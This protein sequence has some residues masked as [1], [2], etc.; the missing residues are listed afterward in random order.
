MDLKALDPC[1]IGNW[2]KPFAWQ[3]LS[4]NELIIRHCSLR[5]HIT[6]M[7]T[8]KTYTYVT[9][10]IIIIFN[11]LLQ[12]CDLIASTLVLC[13]YLV[14]LWCV[15][16]KRYF[17][18]RHPMWFR[19]YYNLLKELTKSSYPNT[20]LTRS[21][22]YDITSCGGN[23]ATINNFGMKQLLVDYMYCEKIC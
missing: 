21:I 7:E 11:A 4:H 13:Y 12:Y 17:R 9:S 10:R 3:F 6:W 1:T 19:V 8:F 16:Y 23:V 15:L 22:T 18:F 20:T 14:L 2:M 5:K